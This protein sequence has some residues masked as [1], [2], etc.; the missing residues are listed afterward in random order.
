SGLWLAL[1]NRSSLPRPAPAPTRPGPPEIPL[2]AP[3]GPRLELLDA[4]A[5]DALVWGIGR[6]T[7]DDATD[8]LDV[9]RSVEAT[10]RAGGLPVLRFQRQGRHR[11]VWLWVDESSHNPMIERLERE[12]TTALGRAR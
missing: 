7:T 5:E 3:A 9:E 10:A 6:F 4:R 12:I 8:A 11:A 1:R 2:A